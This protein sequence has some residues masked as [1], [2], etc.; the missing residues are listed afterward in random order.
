MQWKILGKKELEFRVNKGEF[1]ISLRPDPKNGDDVLELSQCLG[2]VTGGWDFIK[3]LEVRLQNG[4]DT[5]WLD[6]ENV[7]ANQWPSPQEAVK[8]LSEALAEKLSS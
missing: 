7:R 2:P 5:G 4:D 8:L 3:V 6:P 1:I